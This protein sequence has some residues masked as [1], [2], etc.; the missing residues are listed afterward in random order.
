MP[1]FQK[2]IAYG[3][4]GFPWKS[5]FSNNQISYEKGI[6]PVAEELQDKLYLGYEMCLHE[7]DD[8]D[9]KKIIN[10]FEKVW[11]NISHLKL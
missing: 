10:V 8:A 9:V 7:L 1:I 3:N 4:K 6:C 5:E 2:K 11:M